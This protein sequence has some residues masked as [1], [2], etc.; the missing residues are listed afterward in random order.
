M[1][2][3][4]FDHPKMHRLGRLLGLSRGQ[5][6]MRIVLLLDWMERYAPQGDLGRFDDADI[7]AAAEWPTEGDE[8]K[9]FVDALVACRW[10]DASDEHRLIFHDWSE[11]CDRYVHIKLVRKKLLFA[12]GT[13]PNRTGIS[14]KE[15][16]RDGL[17][18]F[19]DEVA[20][21]RR[22]K[23]EGVQ[24]EL[25]Q[26][27]ADCAPFVRTTCAPSPP[28]PPSLLEEE[29]REPEAPARESVGFGP[30]AETVAP[31]RLGDGERTLLRAWARE[32][33]P[34]KVDQLVHLEQL[35]LSYWRP[36]KKSRDWWSE[37]QAFVLR[38]LGDDAAPR[39]SPAALT[40]DEKHA[41][42]RQREEDDARKR[43]K[44]E[45]EDAIARKNR[46]TPEQIQR[47]MDEVLPHHRRTA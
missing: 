5:A 40:R 18:L 33:A 34:S 26:G 14:K 2:R 28:P 6:V 17:D 22:A 20:A 47:I 21:A 45:A 31:D 29:E 11:H 46:A 25:L 16:E 10:V 23:R 39:G 43:E 27:V 41:R 3:G 12:D 19:W 9:R 37:V 8:P 1:K 4:A 32:H 35:A 15:R 42:A 44:R 38:K 7:A 24:G 36:K 30:G 13:I